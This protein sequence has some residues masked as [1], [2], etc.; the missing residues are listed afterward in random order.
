MD[1]KVY[2]SLLG[3]QSC[4]LLDTPKESCRLA[5]A[6]SRK[7]SECKQKQRV[8]LQCSK[9][10]HPRRD[11]ESRERNSETRTEK[12]LPRGIQPSQKNTQEE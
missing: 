5:P 11:R 9:I 3:K 4:P 12:S 8:K 1:V 10:H 7:T 2:M 6:L